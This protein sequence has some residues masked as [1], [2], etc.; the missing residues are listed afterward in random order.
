MPPSPPPPHDLDKHPCFTPWLDPQSGVLSYLLT[1]RLGAVQK[2]WYFMEPSLRGESPLLWFRV[3]HPP[4]TGATCAAVRLD[5]ADPEV[6]HYPHSLSAGNGMLTPDGETAWLPI[7]DGI[8][9]QPFAGEPREMFRLPGKIRGGRH[10]FNLVSDLSLSIDD[11]RF[12]LD[13]HIGNRWLIA[14][15]DRHTGEFTPLRWFGNRH[16]HAVFSKH[17]PDLFMVN[18]GHWTDPITGDK[19]EMNNRIW[20]MDTK[21]TRYA[22]L[23][24][25]AWFGR[26]SWN[27][28]EWWTPD[29]KINL[30]DYERGVVEA[31]PETHESRVI[32]PRTCTHAQSDRHNRWFVGDVNCYKWNERAPCSVWFFNRETGREMPIVSRMPDQPLPWRDFRTYHIDPHPAFSEDGRYIVYTTTAPGYVTVALTPAALLVSATAETL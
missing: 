7:A 17:D 23:L 11:R 24:P 9:E 4:S 6:R 5:P 15:V 31:D 12:V 1:H 26:N 25:E 32:W 27:C 14:T 2:A 3:V 29:G 19:F 28:H 16:H 22:P 18:L 13:C 8:Y 21:L 10:L 30:C 20:V